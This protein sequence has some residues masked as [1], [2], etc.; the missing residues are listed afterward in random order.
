MLSFLHLICVININFILE[1][2]FTA[3]GREIFLFLFR[4]LEISNL[5][6]GASLFLSYQIRNIRF[7][8][9]F[10]GDFSRD[11]AFHQ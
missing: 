2:F 9:L 3:R 10:V 5:A 4:S 8:L 7:F 11:I 6:G 1:L